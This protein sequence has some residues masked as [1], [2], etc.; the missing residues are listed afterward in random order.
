MKW[1]QILTIGL[2]AA[3]IMSAVPVEGMTVY[4]DT[5]IEAGGVLKKRMFR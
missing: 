5:D 1:K 2:S 3:T 4:A